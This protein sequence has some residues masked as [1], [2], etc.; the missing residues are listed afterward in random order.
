MNLEKKILLLDRDGVINFDSDDYIKSV[1]EWIPIPGSLEAIAAASKAGFR[2][3]VVTNQSGLA[4]GYFD[5]ATLD[6]MHQKLKAGVAALGGRIEAIYFCPH[7]PDDQC[8]CRKPNPGLLLQIQQDH[9]LNLEGVP[10][11]G[12]SLKDIQCAQA[13]GAQGILVKTGKGLRTLEK[14]HEQLKETPTYDDLQAVIQFLL[15]EPT[16]IQILHQEQKG[17]EQH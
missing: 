9:Q 11:V 1:A 13:V 17:S 4:R 2:I 16:N 14:H 7:G 8:Q 3:F 5:Q 6:A 10:F 15:T 12:D